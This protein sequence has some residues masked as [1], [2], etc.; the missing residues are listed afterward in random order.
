MNINGTLAKILVI[1]FLCIVIFGSAGYFSYK[2]FVAPQK[3]LKKEMAGPPP[4]PPP[5]PSIA[6]FEKCMKIKDSGTLMEA[7]DAL[8]DFVEHN[9]D[10]TKLVEAKDA[11]GEINMKLFY[12]DQPSPD[13]QQY[14]IQ[15]GD[16]IGAI[17]RKTKMPGEMIMHLN[18]INDPTKLRIGEVLNVS[19]PEFALQV[20]RK[21]KMVDLTNK[22][23]FFKQYKVI[24]WN[25]PAAK[26][27]NPVSAKVSEK[28]AWK[29][30]LRVVFG[31][32]EYA[33]SGRWISLSV[34]GFTL[35]TEGSGADTPK[36]PGGLGME[37]G[38]MDELSSLINRNSP[39]TID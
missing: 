22:G 38:D 1:L 2:L 6:G 31:S 11:L 13:K 14:V 23:K 24:S 29:N 16:T 36:P 10:S 5:D 15:K 3:I 7:H 32:K 27:A 35:Y 18:K 17:E 9:P 37:A 33:G 8:A 34:S 20:H 28:V 12:S 26:N 30:G 19:R 4:T 21:T 25:A 39:A